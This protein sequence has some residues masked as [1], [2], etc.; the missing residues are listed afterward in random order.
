MTTPVSGPDPYADSGGSGRDVR[1]AVPGWSAGQDWYTGPVYDDTG[2]HID[3]SNVNWAGNASTSQ[4]DED[5]AW[6]DGYGD[7]DESPQYD[8]YDRRAGNGAAPYRGRPDPPVERPSGWPEQPPQRDRSE[9]SSGRHARRHGRPDDEQTPGPG[10]RPRPAQRPGPGGQR[11]TG[12]PPPRSLPRRA[13]RTGSPDPGYEPDGYGPSGYQP[14]GYEPTVYEAQA[15]VYEAPIYEAPASDAPPY[16]RRPYPPA[17]RRRASRARAVP[18]RGLA[19]H[20]PADQD[21]ADQDPADQDPAV[22]VPARGRMKPARSP[23]SG[24]AARWRSA[25]LAPG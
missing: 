7:A 12:L 23:S 21:P 18:A 2:W 20:G 24:Q 1:P 25:R 3:L 4:Q 19:E 22:Q 9:R 16:E 11:R 6:A 17:G 13:P 8:G 14:A 5:A 15:P 10:Q